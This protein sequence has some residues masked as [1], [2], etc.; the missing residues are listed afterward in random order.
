MGTG[1]DALDPINYAQEWDVIRVAGVK[2]PGRVSLS[3][4]KRAHEWDVKK[5]KGVKG[6]TITFVQKPPASFKATFELGYLALDGSGGPQHFIDWAKFRPLFEYDPTR[7]AVIAV[8]IYHPSLADVDITSVVTES[9]GGIEHVGEGL[10]R[11]EVEFL[12]YFP[13]APQNA[14]GTPNGSTGSKVA[15]GISGD[16]PGTPPPTAEQLLND[17]N[18]QLAAAQQQVAA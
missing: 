7:K 18:G 2:S 12:E 15:Q 4:I 17:V 10:Y 14:S 8:D 11:V 5:G 13:Q 9:I 16:Q 6:A 1:S 3:E